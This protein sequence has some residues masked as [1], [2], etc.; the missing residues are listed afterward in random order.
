VDTG[1]G[2]GT[3]SLSHIFE[4]FRQA[5]EGAN[6]R[7]GGSGLGLSIV[8][9]LVQAM[10][11]TVTVQSELGHGARFDIELSLPLAA[12]PFHTAISPALQ[13]SGGDHSIHVLV[14]EDDPLNQTIV[15]RL[16]KHAG[17]LS[18]PANDGAQALALLAH[19]NFD[20]VLMDWQMP[21]MDG[22]EVTR[23]MRAGEAG[24]WGKTVPI[25]ALTANAFA[26]DRLACLAAGMN[27][28]L[29]KPVLADRL[30][31]VV[32]QWTKAK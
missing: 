12:K 4:P 21:D 24:P 27:D 1:V 5:D 19:S 28:F 26:E 9:Q 17:Y 8:N 11:G 22:L 29:T 14:V 31:S 18:T 7:F 23:R 15:C 6:R 3:A 20:L 30:M 16:L 13:A 10:G 25:V 32:H 2:I